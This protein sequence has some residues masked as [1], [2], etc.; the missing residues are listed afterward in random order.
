MHAAVCCYLAT[1]TAPRVRQ[2]HWRCLSLLNHVPSIAF[3]LTSIN[4]IS[5]VFSA[6]VVLDVKG[7]EPAV[8]NRVCALD[9]LGG[10]RTI[11]GRFDPVHELCLGQL[12]EFS[13]RRS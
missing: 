11:N 5:E 1:Q 3:I 6:R 9:L 2:N 4:M 7:R 12:R 8:L 13:V 10:S